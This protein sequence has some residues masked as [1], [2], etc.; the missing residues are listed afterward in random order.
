MEKRFVI[1]AIN[2]F[3]FVGILCGVPNLK[4]QT[5]LIDSLKNKSVDST[6]Y[7]LWVQ[8]KLDSL[9]KLNL[10]HEVFLHKI[11]SISKIPF[12]RANAL[13]NRG[14]SIYSYLE[15]K[16][17]KLISRGYEKVDT[18]YD[19]ITL[20]KDSLEYKLNKKAQKL[21]KLTVLKGVDDKLKEVGK[22]VGFKSP[23]SEIGD[24]MSDLAGDKTKLPQLSTKIS[25]KDNAK[26]NTLKEGIGEI[27]QVKE[28]SDKL[29][30]VKDI[31]NEQIA[32]IKNIEEVEKINNKIGEVKEIGEQVNVYKKEVEQ[33]SENGLQ[34]APKS[35]ENKVGKLEGVQE[36]GNQ[37]AVINNQT[38][39]WEKLKDEEYAKQKMIEEA[40]KVTI[41]YFAQ[42]Q[43]KLKEAQKKLSSLKKKYGSLASVSD[44]L[45]K[46]E[47]P[48]KEKLLGQRLRVGMG[49]QL[50]KSKPFG[51]DISPNL[52]YQLTK[53]FSIGASGTYRTSLDGDEK[54]F[55][56]RENEA[57]GIRI[58]T[59]SVL[60]KGFFGH[61]EFERLHTTNSKVLIKDA[62][63]PQNWNNGLFMGLGRTFNFTKGI[64]GN[65]IV[66]Y[67]F[68]NDKTNPNRKAWNIRFG[69][70]L[71]DLSKNKKT[72]KQ[73]RINAIKN[74]LLGSENKNSEAGN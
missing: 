62:S 43:D 24:A 12:D 11:D 60:Y 51:L 61:V 57:Y 74:K 18:L 36:L 14:D 67:N 66:L 5:K 56:T 16:V 1:L 49:F 40:K 63:S 37:K 13:H 8:Q 54:Y 73:E 19:K 64:R 34:D 70:D 58:F 65:V 46:K 28:W 17:S 7:A 72:N 33:L 31:P 26:L 22:K 25:T 44:T 69:F 9:Q 2:T 48:M 3:L 32:K 21:N 23:N 10:P 50:H 29:N 42:H 68:L 27:D 41:D 45:K 53:K 15:T 52:S 59:E 30:E 39:E 6:Y 71:G 4:A 38:D 20:K 35:I 55:I 47:N